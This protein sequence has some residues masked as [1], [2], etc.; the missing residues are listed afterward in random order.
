MT[1]P[2]P[3]LPPLLPAPSYAPTDAGF[4]TASAAAGRRRRRRVVL[5]SGGVATALALWTAAVLLSTPSGPQVLDQAGQPDVVPRAPTSAPAPVPPD[6]GTTAATGQPSPAVP[7]ALPSLVVEVRPTASP[8]RSSAPSPTPTAPS[9]TG[10]LRGPEPTF[11]AYEVGQDCDGSGY[12]AANG[13]CSAHSGARTAR[14]GSTDELATSL[15]RLPGQAV[16]TL[17]AETGQYAE[18]VLTD[19]DGAVR[20]TWSRGKRFAEEP[21]AFTVPAGRCLRLA[22]T[23]DVRDDRGRTLPAGDYVLTSS[24]RLATPGGFVREQKPTAFTVS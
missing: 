11:T 4:G 15:W 2:L 14:R 3:G 1:E 19:R 21:R 23:W 12:T 18:F 24:P 13:W 5:G 9:T 17:R 6:T 20:W 16:G 8:S 7:T 10:G 22:V